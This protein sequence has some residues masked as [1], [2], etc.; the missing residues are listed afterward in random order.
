MAYTP[1][2]TTPV[3]DWTPEQYDEYFTLIHESAI[4]NGELDE[5]FWYAGGR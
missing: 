5:D 3:K 1:R 2:P 4:C